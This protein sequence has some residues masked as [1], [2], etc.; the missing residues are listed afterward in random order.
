MMNSDA[1]TVR[2]LSIAVLVLSILSIVGALFTLAFLGIGGFA[3]SDPDFVGSAAIELNA[4]PDLQAYNLD[5][6]DVMGAAML[7]LVVM[8]VA[9]GWCILCS[10]VTLI[11]SIIGMR[12]CTKPEKLGGVFGWAVAGAVF[13]FLTGRLVTMVLLI[14]SAV[15][16]SKLKKGTMPLPYG[17]K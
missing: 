6:G 12:N 17:Q 14:V 16:A 4:D 13:A 7:S 8:S 15:F 1:R 9:T 2:G 5:S 10:I 3:L 11:A